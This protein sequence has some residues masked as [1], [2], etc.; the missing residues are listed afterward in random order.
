MIVDA[1]DAETD[2]VEG[3]IAVGVPPE[4]GEG[5]TTWVGVDV[6]TGDDLLP[7]SFSTSL[8]EGTMG[9]GV[10]VDVV[11]GDFVT[12][13]GTTVEIAGTVGFCVCI[14]VCNCEFTCCFGP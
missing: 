12:T 5:L 11:I 1:V 4:A 6:K 9:V 10:S 8:L 3:G 7:L 14:W 2:G 13:G